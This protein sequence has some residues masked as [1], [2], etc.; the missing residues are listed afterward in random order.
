MLAPCHGVV[1]AF[2]K[3]HGLSSSGSL[4]Q[5][6][7]H[8]TEYQTCDAIALFSASLCG[9][10]HATLATRRLRNVSLPTGF[11]ETAPELPKAIG[12]SAVPN[13]CFRKLGLVFVGVLVIEVLL[14]LG[15]YWGP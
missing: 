13:G 1:F 7:K 8:Y 12:H 2:R 9:V 11:L 6:C 4:T 3:G 5:T 15:P 14:L 10:T